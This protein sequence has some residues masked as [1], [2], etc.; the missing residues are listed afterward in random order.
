VPDLFRRRAAWL[1][2]HHAV[3]RGEAIPGA[4]A[5]PAA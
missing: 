5:A 2:T 1:E 3:H 4:S